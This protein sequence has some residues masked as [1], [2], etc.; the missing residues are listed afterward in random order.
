MFPF[1]QCSA[2]QPRTC[3]THTPSDSRICKVGPNA[4]W[5]LQ[6]M[7][8]RWL[9]ANLDQ[10]LPSSRL[11]YCTALLN[12]GTSTAVPGIYLHRHKSPTT[13]GVAILPEATKPL[14]QTSPHLLP[15]SWPMDSRISLPIFPSRYYL[16]HLATARKKVGREVGRDI[17]QGNGAVGKQWQESF[18]IHVEPWGLEQGFWEEQGV[19]S[20]WPPPKFCSLQDRDKHWGH[21]TQYNVL[22]PVLHWFIFP[23]APLE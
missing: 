19:E 15:E 23:S 21:S 12:S 10:A 17:L 7:S 2:I 11:H 5:I 9:A 1:S 16:H 20:S 3:L 6:Y 4:L 22:S 8:F 18:T 13:T 14:S